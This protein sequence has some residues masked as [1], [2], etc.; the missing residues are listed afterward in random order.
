MRY[1]IYFFR[2]FIRAVDVL[3]WLQHNSTSTDEHQTSSSPSWRDGTGE[4][5]VIVLTEAGKKILQTLEEQ[6][7]QVPSIAVVVAF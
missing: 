1:K 7:K 3:P 2:L 5:N 6:E 4:C